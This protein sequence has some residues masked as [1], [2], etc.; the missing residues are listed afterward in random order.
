LHIKKN[1]RGI[2]GSYRINHRHHI[3]N[4]KRG[5]KTCREEEKGIQNLLGFGL[6]A[7]RRKKTDGGTP[8]RRKTARGRKKTVRTEVRR[9]GRRWRGG[10]RRQRGQR[11][12]AAAAGNGRPAPAS[13]LWA[14]E[15]RGAGPRGAAFWVLS[16][17][18]GYQH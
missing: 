3:G 14:A 18:S 17:L 12:T 6:P 11:D 5:S 2:I 1:N 13:H 8:S 9:G 10:G 7:R 16:Q 15:A 4:K